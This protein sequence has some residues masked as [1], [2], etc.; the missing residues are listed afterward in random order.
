MYFINQLH[1]KGYKTANMK[2]KVKA[3]WLV[4][5]YMSKVVEVELA[6]ECATIA[7]DQII[8]SQPRYPS[9]VDWDECGGTHKYYYEAQREEA[10]KY[11]QEVKTEI[12]NL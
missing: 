3:A 9:E 4:L 10:D 11:W 12:N 8:E 1:P 7:V 5:K 2:P 6:K